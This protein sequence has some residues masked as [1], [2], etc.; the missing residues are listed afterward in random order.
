M[1]NLQVRARE[2]VLSRDTKSAF[3]DSFIFEPE[4]IEEQALGNLYIIGEVTNYSENSSY[5]VNLLISVL[6]REFYANSKRSPLDSLENALH[7]ANSTLAD[8]AEQGNI[9]WINNLN[10]VIAVLKDGVLHFSQT[11]YCRVVLVRDGELADISQGLIVPEQTASHLKTFANIASGQLESG[12]QIVLATESFFNAVPEGEIKRLSG[13]GFD[14]EMEKFE[15]VIKRAGNEINSTSLIIFKLGADSETEKKF[16]HVE[17][18]YGTEKRSEVAPAPSQASLTLEQIVKEHAASK[19]V[20]FGQ[21]EE[22]LAKFAE[23][24][25]GYNNEGAS[26]DEKLLANVDDRSPG[27]LKRISG[28]LSSVVSK[29]IALI[30]TLLSK[31][32]SISKNILMPKAKKM[33]EATYSVAKSAG[34][35][36]KD[37][38]AKKK[39]DSLEKSVETPVEGGSDFAVVVDEKVSDIPASITDTVPQDL[40]ANSEM[41]RQFE[42]EQV[43]NPYMSSQALG[44][45]IKKRTGL[46][47]E[48]PGILKTAVNPKN[49][50]ILTTVTA[51]VFTI[52]ILFAAKEKKDADKDISV[53]N[54][55]LTKAIQKREAAETAL[56]YQDENKA[57]SLMKEEEEELDKLSATGFF[58]SEVT[59]ERTALRALAGQ[60]D[61]Q[62]T[63]T[64]L[65]AIFNFS[66]LDSTINPAKLTMIDSTIYVFDASKNSLYAYDT[67]KGTSKPL[68]VDSTNI[69]HFK[70]WVASSDKK[71]IIYT[72]TPGL[73]IY[74]PK[75]NELK[76]ADSVLAKN[77]VTV[78]DM[79]TYDTSLYVM[80][81]AA[82]Q[83]IKYKRTA[84]G[85]DAGKEW[86][87]DKGGKNLSNAISLTIDGTIYV[88]NTDGQIYKYYKGVNS[89]LP[90]SPLFTP[91]TNPLKIV[92]GGSLKNLY[93]LDPPNNRIVVFGKDG[94]LVKQIYSDKFTALKDI[95]IYDEKTAFV[96]NGTAIYKIGL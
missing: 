78:K 52:S 71:I 31:F 4:N 93:V 15:E 43:R 3:A 22:K 12:D 84:S 59:K 73:A 48:M 2:L 55:M 66:D 6:K 67:A 36:V 76:A 45:I 92:T 23:R 14:E 37:N 46:L 27:A 51:V 96:L 1:S 57:K 33:A 25:D 32:V 53:Y 17:I 18:S 65:A 34:I 41:G 64:D 58:A 63:L 86:I 42:Q 81:S 89:D 70:Q 74:D 21:A 7:K 79:T 72:D 54:V 30:K 80:D 91:L 16:N 68:N 61:K 29:M 85:F 47:R 50:I 56:I 38:L 62:F 5:L 88:L 69:G 49:V 35:K 90:L 87:A 75:K 77:K 8:F 9:E 44:G 10:V 20:E 82:D 19:D 11:G 40:S 24:V 60:I 95:I 28:I 39:V 13:F 83:I 94:K 26:Q